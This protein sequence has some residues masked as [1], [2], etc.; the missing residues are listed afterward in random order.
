MSNKTQK[1][2]LL[3]GRFAVPLLVW[4][5]IGPIAAVLSWFLLKKRSARN[6]PNVTIHPNY[7]H[8]S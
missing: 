5:I 1:P 2:Y 6:N 7:L 4:L 3:F 8:R